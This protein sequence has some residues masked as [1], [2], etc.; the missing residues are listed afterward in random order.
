MSPEGSHMK[1]GVGTCLFL[2]GLGAETNRANGKT[3]LLR[4][5]DQCV[6]LCPKCQYVLGLTLKLEFRRVHASNYL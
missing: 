1:T 4:F 5:L 2:F 6:F 3:L